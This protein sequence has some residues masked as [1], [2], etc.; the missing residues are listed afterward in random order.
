MKK[1]LILTALI[2][3]SG[4]VLG[5]DAV[6]A[7]RVKPDELRWK[8]NPFLPAGAQVAVLLGDPT[9]P[10]DVVVQRVKFPANYRIPPHTHPYAE[11]VTVIS[12]R[13]GFGMGEKFETGKGEVVMAG[14]LSTVPVRQPHFVWTEN[15]EAIV[16]VQFI[17]PGGIDYINQADDPRKKPN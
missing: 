8:A 15:E 4:S 9:K 17:G 5:Q 14:T 3:L 6:K 13:L 1:L 16:Q 12:G 7:V 11:V 10:G 2:A